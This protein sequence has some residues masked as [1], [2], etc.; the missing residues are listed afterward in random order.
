MIPDSTRGT[1][2]IIRIREKLDES[3]ADWFEPL[4]VSADG[5]GTLL[6]GHLPDQSA[7]HGVI[8]R[9]QRLGLQLVAV[10]ETEPPVADGA[11]I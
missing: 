6:A 1:Y 4:S 2:Y 8:G 9:V 10:N 7:L 5:D 3:W 11:E